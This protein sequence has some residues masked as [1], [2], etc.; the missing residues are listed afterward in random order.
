MTIHR[1]LRRRGSNWLSQIDPGGRRR[2]LE[3][4]TG[5]PADS[6]TIGSTPPWLPLAIVREL[7]AQACRAPKGMRLQIPGSP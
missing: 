6:P 4:S 5:D 1:P 7:H 2:S 3:I